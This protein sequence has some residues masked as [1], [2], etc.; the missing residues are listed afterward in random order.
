VPTP[1]LEWSTNSHRRAILGGSRGCARR[2][3][4]DPGRRHHGFLTKQDPGPHQHAL[5]DDGVIGADRGTA[6]DT[7][8]HGVHRTTVKSTVETVHDGFS[9]GVRIAFAGEKNRPRAHNET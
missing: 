5:M 3:A 9:I 4:N 2:T 7:D 1:L 6:V 8:R